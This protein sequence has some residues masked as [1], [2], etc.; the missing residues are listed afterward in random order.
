MNYIGATYQYQRLIAYPKLGQS[1]T[2][3]H[4]LL[5]FYTLYATT[6]LSISFFGGPQYSNTIAPPQPPLLT[7]GA[8]R[9]AWTPGAGASLSWQ[10]RFSNIALSYSHVISGGGGLIGAV[11]LSSASA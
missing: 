4:A 7:Q 11:Q 3:T 9:R 10:G 2:E 1:A 8:T 5:F 6:G